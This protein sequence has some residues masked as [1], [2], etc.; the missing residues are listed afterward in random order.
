MIKKLL[1]TAALLVPGLA[2]GGNPSADLSI[3]IVPASGPAVP[4]AAQAAGFTTHTIADNFQDG[5]WNNP[6]TW[7]D[8]AGAS[9]PKY[10]MQ[11]A[12]FA[13]QA[14]C[15]SVS[16]ATDPVGGQLAL[17]LHWQDSYYG[18]KGGS[19]QAQGSLI[20]TA[21]G[22]GVGRNIPYN[23]YVEIVARQSLYSSHNNMALWSANSAPAGNTHFE[24]DGL[25]TF[26][27]DVNNDAAI[28]NWDAGFHNYSWQG[29]LPVRGCVDWTQYHKVAWRL[30]SDGVTG[31]FACS[32]VDD[33]VQNC[34]STHPIANQ[35]N[36]GWPMWLQL[37]SYGADAN[38][39][40]GAVGVD[41]WIKSVNVWSCHPINAG[42]FCPSSSNNP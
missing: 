10:Y 22:N 30:T 36:S 17:R 20:E 16:L 37:G 7:L 25:E 31:Q 34:Q 3:Q 13:V 21:D 33:A 41:V 27:P 23:F 38:I 5:S 9:S 39:G 26:Y 14:P 8:C 35:I 29:C 24:Y 32:Y 18:S 42:L 11:W 12:G 4:A 28:H 2:Y 40:N 1:F 15:S 6:A 19:A